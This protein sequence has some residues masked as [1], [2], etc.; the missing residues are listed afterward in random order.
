[1]GIRIAR[2]AIGRVFFQRCFYL[3]FLLLAMIAAVPFVDPTARGR[4]I[5]TTINV[6]LLIAT[7]AAVG[8]AL[9]SFVFVIVLALPT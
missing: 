8:R 9:L 3:F 7:V 4:V 5:V 1:M 6:L 2:D